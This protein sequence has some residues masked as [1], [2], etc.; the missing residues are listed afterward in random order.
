V[1]KVLDVEEDYVEEALNL[2]VGK[3]NLNFSSNDVKWCP[4]FRKRSSSTIGSPIS[5]THGVS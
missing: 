3:V 1:L 2:R 4:N 5:R